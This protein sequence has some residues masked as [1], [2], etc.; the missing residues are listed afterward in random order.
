MVAAFG[1][2]DPSLSVP[3]SASFQGEP[4]E[5]PGVTKEFLGLAFQSFLGSCSAASAASD[6]GSSTVEGGNSSNTGPALWRY[7]PAL[8]TYWFEE[9]SKNPNAYHACGVL[10]GQ[11]VLTSTRLQASFPRVL[12]ARLLSSLGSPHVRQLGLPDL[13]TVEP[14]LA[15][16]LQELLAYEGADVGEIYPLNWPRS[17]ELTSSNR[18]EHVQAFVHWFFTERFALQLAPLCEGFRSV[19]GRSE[20]L[21]GLVDPEQLEQIICGLESPLDVEAVKLNA[22]V[23][24]WPASDADYIE[25]FW[26]VLTGLGEADQRRFIVFVSACARMPPQGWQNFELRLQRNGECDSRLPTAY[27]CFSLLLLPRYSSA[28]ILRERLLAAINETEGFGLS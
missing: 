8:R 7:E 25:S 6:Q 24:G 22:E 23:A 20:L 17:D 18:K 12:Y 10:L 27:T 19:L 5:G 15:R 9:S 16:G 26:Q 28:E 2:P 21:R 1:S 11:A 14:E 3:V 13:A 4:G